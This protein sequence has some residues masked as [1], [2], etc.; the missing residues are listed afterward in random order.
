MAEVLKSSDNLKSVV[1]SKLY[2][3]RMKFV[4]HVFIEKA[5]ALKKLSKS[6][7]QSLTVGL[8]NNVFR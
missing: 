1:G 8:T 6:I 7:L 3:A 2:F 4:V 5:V